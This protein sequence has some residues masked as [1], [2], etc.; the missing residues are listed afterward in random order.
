V[1]AI[2]DDAIKQL[3]DKQNE[4]ADS[5][6]NIRNISKS[7]HLDINVE[8]EGNEIDD[9]IDDVE[10]LDEGVG[11]ISSDG[12]NHDRVSIDNTNTGSLKLEETIIDC[13]KEAT[14]EKKNISPNH[15]K[16]RIPSIF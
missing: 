14:K 11:D 2:S 12:E 5:G 4:P 16:E 15:E 6:D 13:D 10:S 8:S 9:L 3:D 1:T 7:E